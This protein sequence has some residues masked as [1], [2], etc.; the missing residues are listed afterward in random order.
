MFSDAVAEPDDVE[1]CARVSFFEGAYYLSCLH[2]QRGYGVGAFGQGRVEAFEHYVGD[3]LFLGEDGERLYTRDEVS[4]VSERAVLNQGGFVPPQHVHEDGLG[5]VV[6]V[7]PRCY[8]V[9]IEAACGF[10]QGTAPQDSADA[11]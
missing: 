9:G 11:A 4:R 10:G 2:P 6:E 1:F 3:D 7:V 5:F 8:A